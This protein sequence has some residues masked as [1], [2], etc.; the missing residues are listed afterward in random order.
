MIK[1]DR[2]PFGISDDSAE[3]K[4]QG[5][6]RTLSV[7]RLRIRA[8]Q[9][10]VAA[11]IF[12]AL[13]IGLWVSSTYQ[14]VSDEIDQQVHTALNRIASPLTLFLKNI[15]DEIPLQSMRSGFNN[16]Q[17][18]SVLDSNGDF[19][20]GD[21]ASPLPPEYSLQK[22]IETVE[23]R[24]TASI[25]LPFLAQGEWYATV[26]RTIKSSGTEGKSY[27]ASTFRVHDFMTRWAVLGLPKRSM[28][29]IQTDDGQLWLDDSFSEDLIGRKTPYLLSSLAEQEDVSVWD[30]DG[31]KRI[32]KGQGIDHFG[33]SVVIGI[34]ADYIEVV[35]R[36]RYSA[37][38]GFALGA[39]LVLIIALYL[40]GRIFVTTAQRR[41]GAVLALKDSERRF[42]DI[43][44][45]AT[46]WF[47]EMGPDLRF[48]FVSQLQEWNLLGKSFSD[49]K[50][51]GL[52]DESF[53]KILK[54]RSSFRDLELVVPDLA[55][56]NRILRL[57]GVPVFDKKGE[58]KGYRG[59]GS[60]IT[61]RRKEQQKMAT[62]H[63]RLFRAFES[64]SG[65]VTLYDEND[66][67][68]AFN[69]RFQEIFFP[70]RPMAIRVGMTY[71]DVSISYVNTGQDPLSVEKR[72]SYIKAMMSRRGKRNRE[73]QFAEDSWLKITDH[74]TPE[75]DLFTVYT[76]ISDYKAREAELMD[77]SR[78][79]HRLAAA[80][81]STDAGVIIADAQQENRPII[82][83]NPA[84]TKLTGYTNEEIPYLH[85]RFLQGDETDPHVQDVLEKSLNENR[86]ARVDMLNYHR[87][88]H[89]LWNQIDLSPIF[90]DEGSIQY[91]VCV[92]QD[93]TEQKEVEK[94][95]TVLKESAELANRAKSEFM[96]LMSHELR[97]PLNAILGFSEILAN[98]MF[99]PLGSPRYKDYARDVNES[100]THLLELINDILDLSKAE[101]GKIELHE[102]HFDIN[103]VVQR[104]T[105]MLSGRAEQANLSVLL[106]L[107]P[108]VPSLCGDERRIKQVL[109]NLIS[110]GIK[111]T[112]SG[113]S[114]TITTHTSDRGLELSVMD[115][116][117]GMS[118]SEI[119][120]ALA[121]FGQVDSSLSRKHEGT[122]LGLPLSKRLT[123]LHGA[124]FLIE[125][126]PNVGTTVTLVF[127]IE[128]QRLTA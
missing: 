23:A 20:L 118:S 71:E 80:V 48:T 91:F 124:Q 74:K 84:F 58:F 69:R 31:V 100:G 41:D 108:N 24:S 120:K 104:C 81:S 44:G 114:I 7:R 121:P 95:L 8:I 107:D 86:H 42:R 25:S 105:K 16:V 51:D 38:V 101:A 49:V 127:P 79:N 78:E 14:D 125:S 54:S 65:A 37:S 17:F 28:V 63:A 64:F 99:G 35:W 4:H 21:K 93:I 126:A 97:T 83:T 55:G 66:K 106:Q 117:I 113:G 29:S 82:Y 46:D 70:G 9:L 62:A 43:A 119:P 45:A 111:F 47:W 52:T 60:D 109:I 11:C 40:G 57:S 32:V 59:A 96:A 56:V 34:P 67:L 39:S 90:D 76:D 87:D 50:G 77:L 112:L 1:G 102:E 122:G 5:L 22:L 128:A 89:T 98:E 6:S 30:L 3:A 10:N 12:S 85:S 53:L 88:G 94:E 61:E 116:G 92:M 2:G 72:E 110:N 73:F 75:N 27:V 26:L 13:L 15:D 115:T 18:L 123:E 33:L 103:N 19:I 36:D 68:V